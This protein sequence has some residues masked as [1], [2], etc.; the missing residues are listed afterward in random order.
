MC[1]EFFVPKLRLF[2][3]AVSNDGEQQS[4]DGGHQQA[5]QQAD[6]HV[7]PLRLDLH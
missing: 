4:H 3:A 2:A 1:V 6:P 5:E 7:A